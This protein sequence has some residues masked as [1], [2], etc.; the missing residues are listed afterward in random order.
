MRPVRKRALLLGAVMVVGTLTATTWSFTQ[1]AAAAQEDPEVVQGDIVDFDFD[2]HESGGNVVEAGTPVRF[3]NTGVRPHT[4]TDRAGTFDVLVQPGETVEI[5]PTIPGRISFFCKIRAAAPGS[6][7]GMDA[8]LDV[9]PTHEHMVN[10]IQAVDGARFGNERAFDPT[11]M[12]V[13]AGSTVLVANIG[14]ETHTLTA[15]DGTFDTGPIAHG[16]EGGRFAGSNATILVEQ[17]GTYP[18]HCKSHPEEMRGV[19]TVEGGDEPVAD[20]LAVDAESPPEANDNPTA[21]VADPPEESSGLPG[22]AWTTVSLAGLGGLLMG[23]AVAAMIRNRR[24][25]SKL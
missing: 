6:P 15:D 2:F 8:T 11:E 5:T 18:Y 13:A 7:K 23:L 3:T 12:T 17:P 14:G 22:G 20:A 9:R 4:V 1:A 10:R 21:I 16:A 19:L 25:S 24:R